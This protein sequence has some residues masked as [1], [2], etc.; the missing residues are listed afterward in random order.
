MDGLCLPSRL[1]ESSAVEL[2]DVKLSHTEAPTMGLEHPGILLFVAD[3][4]TNPPAD[5]ILLKDICT[6]GNGTKIKR[7]SII[8]KVRRPSSQISKYNIVL[9]PKELG[10]LGETA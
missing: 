5:T 6:D 8:S 1:T 7:E 4:R 9:Q 10:L 2:A 3:P